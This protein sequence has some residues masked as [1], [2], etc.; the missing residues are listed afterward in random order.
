MDM[1]ALMTFE[2][3]SAAERLRERVGSGFDGNLSDGAF[4][5][6]FIAGRRHTPEDVRAS[7]DALMDRSV[8]GNLSWVVFPWEGFRL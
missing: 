2:T 6:W 8:K 1:G 3:L 7:V 4:H 5:W